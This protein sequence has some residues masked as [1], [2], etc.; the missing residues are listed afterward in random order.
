M[1]LSLDFMGIASHRLFRLF[2]TPDEDVTRWPR[3]PGRQD[4]PDRPLDTG[5]NSPSSHAPF[6]P[7]AYPDFPR[8]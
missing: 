7:F 2:E 4:G 6:K 3:K 1:T 8:F 5:G